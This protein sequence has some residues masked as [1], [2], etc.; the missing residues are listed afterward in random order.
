MTSS[1]SEFSRRTVIGGAAAVAGA[2]LGAGWIRPAA[3]SDRMRT[4]TGPG[5][6]SGAPNL[7]AGFTDTFTSR[8]I[9][10]GDVRLHAVVGGQG[11]PLLLVH[12]WPESWYAWRLV[13]PTLARSFQ[14]VAVDQRGMGLSDKPTTGYDAATVAHD[15]AGLM[16]ALGHQQFAVVGHD[17]GMVYSYA[18]AA[19]YPDRVDHLAVAETSLPGISAPVPLFQPTAANNVLWHVLFNRIDKTNELLVRGRED[20]FFGYEFAH[21]TAQPMPPY[22]IKH[23]VDHFA[24]S[25]DALRGS[26]EFYRALDTTAAQNTQRMNRH[27]TMPVLTIGGDH[28]LKATVA[29]TMKA[30]ADNVQTLVVPNSAHFVAEEAPDQLLATLIPFL[31]S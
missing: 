22:V 13:M 4:P 11:H 17:T 27:L 3:A 25:R 15:L 16:D 19:D 31:A 30:T 23:Y 24:A 29:D 28:S 26:F 10:V 7:P 21:R 8:Y 5:S 2:A 1:S 12:G 20:I 9:T 6:V 14:V 18:L